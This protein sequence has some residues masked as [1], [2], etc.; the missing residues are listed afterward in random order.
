MASIGVHF[1][2]L[3]YLT[4]IRPKQC[5]IPYKVPQNSKVY[6]DLVPFF[7][8]P[9]ED[10]DSHA[11]SI[12]KKNQSILSKATIRQMERVGMA[13]ELF[14]FKQTKSLQDI[15]NDM[16]ISY[17]QLQRDFYAFLGMTP[18]EYERLSR[19]QV[20]A[21]NIKNSSNIKTALAAGYYDQAHMIKEFKRFSDK[22][23]KQIAKLDD[24]TVP[25]VDGKIT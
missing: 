10:W 20:A 16:G 25:F 1:S 13:T 17:R 8:L 12:M 11:L 18:S 2:L 5:R 15:S 24:I 23:P 9:I 3:Y 4:G 6:S 7:H 21:S 14:S 19:Y 22:T